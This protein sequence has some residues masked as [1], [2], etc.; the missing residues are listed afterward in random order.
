MVELPNHTYLLSIPTLVPDLLVLSTMN[1]GV[2]CAGPN[3]SGISLVDSQ[4]SRANDS[5]VMNCG[6]AEA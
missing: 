5:L 3:R 1:I 4:M 2:G 6:I